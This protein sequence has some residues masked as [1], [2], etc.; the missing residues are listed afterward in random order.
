MKR[1]IILILFISST[2][3]FA[4]NIEKAEYFFDTDPGYGN[5]TEIAI[6]DTKGQTIEWTEVPSGTNF[7]LYD[8]FFIDSLTGFISGRD[9]ILKTVNGGFSWYKIYEEEL[10]NFHSVFFI[11]SDTGWVAGNNEIL[12]TINGGKDW[13]KEYYNL[14]PYS[15][16]F[17]DDKHGYIVCRSEVIL[18]TK[19]GGNSW[20]YQDA[21][22]HVAGT[23]LYSVFFTDS[24]HGYAGGHRLYYTSDGGSTWI[25]KSTPLEI[26]SMFFLN[27]DTGWAVSRKGAIM[28]TVNGTDPSMIWEYQIEPPSWQYRDI[29]FF[30]DSVGYAVGG[31]NISCDRGFFLET[32]DGGNNW[33][34]Y[35][36]GDYMNAL[37]MRE[38][39]PK[40]MVDF[41]GHIYINTTI[42]P[43]SIN[44]LYPEEGAVL[45]PGS[46]CNILWE[47]ENIGYDR[48]KLEYIDETGNT[49]LIDENISATTSSYEW[50]IPNGVKKIILSCLNIK[51]TV[52]VDGKFV[53]L[54]CEKI[55]F[56]NNVTPN[57]SNPDNIIMPGKNLRFK[58]QTKNPRTQN[59]VTLK[60]IIST[61]SSYVT[62]I[63][64]LGT[65]N[66]LLAGETRYTIDEYEIKIHENIPPGE[67]L[68]FEFKIIDEI[69]MQEYV[70]GFCIPIILTT[71]VFFDDDNYV[72]SYGNG[73][74]IVE[75]N[76]IIE[77][78][79][80]VMNSSPYTLSSMSSGTLIASTGGIQ[81]LNT[82]QGAG[83]VIVNNYLYKEIFCP[84]EK[85]LKPTKDFVI[86]STVNNTGDM[87]FFISFS[88]ICNN[89]AM[90][91]G[92][93]FKLPGAQ[94]PNNTFVADTLKNFSIYITG[95]KFIDNIIPNGGNPE[96]L[97]MP[98]KRFRFKVEARN[99]FSENLL[100][101][102]GVI[103]SNNPNVQ[104]TDSIASFNNILQY[105]NQ[106][107]HDEYE[108]IINEDVQSNDLLQFTIVFKDNF[109]NGTC[110]SKFYIPFMISAGILIDDDNF[111][112]S[113]GNNNNKVEHGETIEMIPLVL[114]NQ[115]IH[116]LSKGKLYTT[117]N[118]VEIW[119]DKRGISNFVYD[120][121]D[122]EFSKEYLKPLADF[123]F[124]CNNTFFS[125]LDFYLTFSGTIGS[126]EARFG[127]PFHLV[128][129][130][131][132]E[133][134]YIPDTLMS[135][136]LFF[137]GF[138]LL[139]DDAITPGEAFSFGVSVRSNFS[140]NLLASI[141][142]L[143]SSD[144]NVTIVD[145]ICAYNNIFGSSGEIIN[146]YF[147][148][149]LHDN[150][151]ISSNIKLTLIVTD[152]FIP[153]EVKIPFT[154]P[155]LNLTRILLDDDDSPD[156]QGNNNN[157]IEN[158]ETIELVPLFINPTNS[159]LGYLEGTLTSQNSNVDIWNNVYGSTGLVL[160]TYD[161]FGTGIGPYGPT[162]DYVFEYTGIS[163][164]PIK[165]DLIIKG[166]LS[167]YFNMKWSLPFTL[168][169][170]KFIEILKPDNN[171]TWYSSAD[172]EISWNDN[173][174]NNLKIDLYEGDAFIETITSSEINTGRYQWNIP[175]EFQNGTGY[176]IK[177]TSISDDLIFCFSDTFAI[178]DPNIVFSYP[179]NTSEWQKGHTYDIIW[180]DNII[181][182]VKIELVS[183]GIPDMDIIV[184]TTDESFTWTVP[185]NLPD[186]SDYQIK[187]S[188][189]TYPQVSAFSDFFEIS[190]KKFPI[191]LSFEVNKISFNSGKVISTV[192][193]NGFPTTV[194][195][196][197][198]LTLN[199]G[200]QMML[201]ANPITGTVDTE[202][203]G[204]LTGLLPN[205]TYFYKVIANNSEGSTISPIDSFK[206]LDTKPIIEDIY[207]S[208][209]TSNSVM[210]NSLINANG[211]ST[212]VNFHYGQTDFLELS[213]TGVPPVI[214][215]TDS[216]LV[217][218]L[219]SDLAPATIYYFS[220]EATSSEG[221]SY[222][223]TL[224]FTTDKLSQT[225]S[226]DTIEDKIVTDSSFQLNAIA[227]SGL[228]VSFIIIS[229]N[230]T[231][232]DNLL[233][234]TGGGTITVRA[235][236]D[237]NEDYMAADYVERSF[238]V[239]KFSQVINF[240]VINDKKFGDLPFFLSATSSS[241]LVVQFTI[242]SGPAIVTDSLLT[243]TGA[244]TI[245]VRALQFGNE[246]YKT[247]IPVDQ[248]FLVQKANQTVTFSTLSDYTFDQ[249]PVILT[250]SLSSGLVL[251]YFI[252][253]GDALLSDNSITFINIGQITIGAYHPGNNNYYPSD[254]V[255][256][257]FIVQKANQTVTFST[258]SE[259]TFDQSPVILTGSL[260]SG[261]VLTYFIE[262]CD[263]LLSGNS[264][265][266]TNIGQITIGAYHPGN[267]YYNPSDTVYSSFTINIGTQVISFESIMDKS[268]EEDSV[269]L[270]ASSSSGLEIL[271]EIISGNVLINGN[272]LQIIGAGK[273]WIKAYQSENNCY[274]PAEAYQSFCINPDKPVI[275]I[276]SETNDSTILE[277][278]ES[279]EY[280]WIKNGVEIDG[281]DQ[282]KLVVFEDGNY[283]VIVAIDSCT[284]ISDT[285]FI[286]I[287]AT[288][289]TDIIRSYNVKIY[290]NPTKGIFTLE[291]PDIPVDELIVE[292]IN[293]N[294]QVIYN[295]KIHNIDGKMIEIVDLSQQPGGIYQIKIR[296]Q[297]TVV[298]KKLIIF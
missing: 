51:D 13:E 56:F 190:E 85:Y 4:Q 174:Y 163:T 160:N 279:K 72:D 27:P 186:R 192:N 199:L 208:N 252:E 147:R 109:V 243:I 137:S 80:L 41:Y 97:I 267:N 204:D 180:T 50:L 215:G 11:N 228:P 38:S 277:S 129:G 148:V 288:G 7:P 3:L 151:H 197:Y 19:D 231:I 98:G 112:D 274:N 275:T 113:N 102:K 263:A 283:S 57:S 135:N 226:F 176:R 282:R 257:S 104:I 273:V 286:S 195:L 229:G 233:T 227:S 242:I 150:R 248:T 16:Y 220:V 105:E 93:P 44:I 43:P 35:E 95:I 144:P 209:I 166:Y 177:L 206:T 138:G 213:V 123:V 130:E 88:G 265:T 196:D 37:F 12:K 96:N 69:T 269:E 116:N 244:G 26:N 121:Y 292:I 281:A 20:Q 156:S 140:E 65:Y 89:I 194:E 107:S 128:N 295:Q 241:G 212:T 79:P 200:N 133:N 83:E 264:I 106:V 169:E 293:A 202:L 55:E 8:I 24:L 161:Y 173:L 132:P 262:T 221:S 162:V 53:Q 205:T 118:N 54:V 32:N 164:N 77:I 81:V 114:T 126:E 168:N 155:L 298:L 245:T 78:F 235:L 2:G 117:S 171:T 136:S 111:E 122:F 251:T 280:Q 207:T 131:I 189:I 211:F 297:E 219:L 45:A 259:Y 18:A 284:N 86:K 25:R 152:E 33:N 216:A 1:L 170:N 5:A 178:I 246:M 271:F 9:Y 100:T 260:S 268:L 181:E 159:K 74:K 46:I 103:R 188:S 291:I 75:M 82:V 201:T 247:A 237:G 101:L 255:Y 285:V 68:L 142:I 272:I 290:P 23:D 236:Q 40:C 58:I 59:F 158:G 270:I 193:P 42:E 61:N 90:K 108:I 146:D 278:S 99:G 175:Y 92:A 218:V 254:T 76:E 249:S 154:I 29:Y 143:K 187:I 94:M 210:L 239:E 294:G 127:I 217:S 172:F 141:G 120:N 87:N 258:P 185:V 230:A 91:W 47:T 22:I 70:S 66:N 276:K 183:Q 214:S 64:E 184:S 73:N 198:G 71:D 266:F 261:L 157:W 256:S 225:I 134:N 10:Q 179:D 67:N 62:I 250:G 110:E 289:K 48:L 39:F 296:I 223:D 6:T 119:N 149:M 84:N 145:S 165:F 253:T 36:I 34:T 124:T 60:G 232:T 17:P 153:G 224:F 287:G 15:I 191:I 31:G 182:P 234:I 240:P 14:R 125:N 63:D 203:T 52:T 167:E 21:G 139:N 115:L 28:K 222:S 30:N 238:F 49:V